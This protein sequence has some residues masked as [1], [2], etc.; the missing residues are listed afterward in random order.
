MIK[1]GLLSFARLGVLLFCATSLIQL[2]HAGEPLLEAAK[3][4]D[5]KQV[6][7]LLKKSNANTSAP[8]GTTALHWAALHD[9]AALAKLLLKAGARPDPS[10]EYGVTPLY[11]ACTNRSTEMV[12][13]LLKAGA[14]PNAALPSGETVL[15]NCSRTGAD[16][17][18]S[19]LIDA[20]ADVNRSENESGQTALMWAA[21]AA[22]ASVVDLLIRN[23]A[24]VKARTKPG[25]PTVPG[26]CRVCDW[27][28][29]S[30]D[31]TPLL[32]AARSGDIETAKRLLDAGADP[33]E[34]T[35]L[36]GNS[37][38]IASA[39][40]HEDLA[41]Y[42]LERGADF[43]STDENGIT[44]LHHAVGAGL[45][46]LNGVIYDKVYRLRPRNLYRLAEALLKAGADPNARIREEQLLG[47]DGYPFTMVGATPLFLATT[48]ADIRMMNILLK[49]GADPGIKNDQDITLLMAAAQVA[50]TG[51]CAYQAGGNIADKDNIAR[52]LETVQEVMKLGMDVNAV[53]DSG[54]TA[55]H[56]AAF[57]GADPVVQYL[58][59]HGASI[60]AENKDGETPWTM[61]LG[62]SPDY[63]S[64]GLYGHHESTAALLQK[65]GAK[66]RSFNLVEG[67]A[68]E[69][70]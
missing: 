25:T 35:T 34:A 43:R 2:V 61:A 33:N 54:R 70:E 1:A 50:C 31:F 47:P 65:L 44:A 26:T 39:G 20:E 68:A 16:E 62:L 51:T 53:D 64:R 32:F 12:E 69:S 10:N 27:K 37:L 56:I 8:D 40:G 14:D 42:L 60:D 11:L 30:G 46:Q 48:A 18:V 4:G 66:P 41:L 55:M 57:T 21:T 3:R 15:M 67:Q 17:A 49:G 22:D 36:H 23:G 38:V 5:H 9:D 28:V 63:G 45:S 19:R 58:A 59:D 52:A 29:T 7:V 13:T 6:Q 24:D